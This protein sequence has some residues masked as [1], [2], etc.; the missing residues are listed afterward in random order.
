M[1]AVVTQDQDSNF[2]SSFAVEE[3]IREA[4]HFCSA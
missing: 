2:G 3:V 1:V 4:F